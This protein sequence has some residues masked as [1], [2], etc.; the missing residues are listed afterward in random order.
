MK[1]VE[2]GKT[3]KKLFE[4]YEEG[5]TLEVY[6]ILAHLR[7]IDD[8]KGT[9][10]HTKT[11]REAIKSLK[12]NDFTHLRSKEIRGA[13]IEMIGLVMDWLNFG[14][15]YDISELIR[16]VEDWAHDVFALHKSET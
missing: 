5:K 11:I 9:Q 8:K 14:G 13:A 3:L 4:L 1:I 12:L 6:E 15:L 16:E 10:A 2:K 7:R